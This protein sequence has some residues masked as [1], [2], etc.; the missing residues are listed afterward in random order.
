[1]FMLIIKRIGK[2]DAKIINTA[3]KKKSK[4]GG[5]PLPDLGICLKLQQTRECGIVG[6]NHNSVHGAA[7]RAQNLTHSFTV[8]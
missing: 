3:W 4:A 5:P 1:M 6:T 7:K 8:N 2:R